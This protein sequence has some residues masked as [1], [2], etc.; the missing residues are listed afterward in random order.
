MFEYVSFA[1]LLPHAPVLVP[2]VGGEYLSQVEET[3][4]AL[5][6]VGRRIAATS[7]DTLV[8]LSPHS[9]YKSGAA[10][11]WRTAPLRGSFAAF[12]AKGQGV[13]LPLDAALADAI[14]EE[15]VRRSIGC[16][17]IQRGGLDHGATVPLYHLMSA[18]WTRP[19]CVV[20][21]GDLENQKLDELGEAI[22]AAAAAVRRVIVV[23]AS[24]DMSHR[25][26][27]TAPCGYAP[28][29]ERFDQAF[30]ELLATGTPDAIRRFDGDLRGLAAE[31]VVA[32]TRAALAAT[33]FAHQG[34]EILSYEG[35]FGVGYTVAILVDRA[36]KSATPAPPA[37]GSVL[38]DIADLPQ[39]ARQSVV[40]ALAGGPD[41]LPYTASGPLT[42][43]R[44]VFVSLHTV[45]DELRGCR[46]LPTG[47]DRDLVAST[48]AHAREAAFDDPRFAPLKASELPN[49]RFTVS[50]LGELERVRSIA[51]LDPA[52]YGVLVSSSDGTRRGLLLPGIKTIENAAEQIRIAQAKAGLAAHEAVNLYRFTTQTVDELVVP[53]HRGL[54]HAP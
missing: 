2:S 39:V 22:A 25:L 48:W 28:E 23:I 10:G 19:A 44:G 9:P 40:A 16:W 13:E 8:V 50:V 7:T 15:C 51:A 46:G 43:R 36:A 38:A 31:D 34:R 24:G 54:A 6:E 14:E 29:G 3:C 45:D 4:T 35:P 53:E 33:A 27:A 30:V 49:V 52:K 20:G 37:A 32:P 42:A 47:D 26:T 12:G 17:R 1:A 41:T 11:I 5:V 18:G 21:L